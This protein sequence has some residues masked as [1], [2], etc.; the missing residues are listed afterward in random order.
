MLDIRSTK[1]HQSTAPWFSFD[2]EIPGCEALEAVDWY[3]V[4]RQDVLGARYW[5]AYGC[6]RLYGTAENIHHTSRCIRLLRYCHMELR[7]LL[8]GIGVRWSG[9]RTLCFLRCC[10]RTPVALLPHF[11]EIS[12]IQSGKNCNCY[13]TMSCSQTSCWMLNWSSTTYVIGIR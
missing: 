9:A 1:A 12:S 2:A 13:Q 7:E 8:V 5:T 4:S 11:L 3:S 10:H 6:V